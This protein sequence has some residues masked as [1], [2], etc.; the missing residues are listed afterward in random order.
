MRERDLE[1]THVDTLDLGEYV[2]K[3]KVHRAD[4]VEDVVNEEEEDDKDREE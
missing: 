4:H 1:D 2:L 3:I